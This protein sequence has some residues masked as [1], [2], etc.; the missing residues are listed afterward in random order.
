LNVLMALIFALTAVVFVLLY[1]GPYRNP[2][3]LSP[4]FAGSLCLFGIA[5]FSTGEFIR[6]AVRKPYIV[7]NVVLANQVLPTEVTNLRRD[8]YLEQGIWTKAFLDDHYP[9]VMLKDQDEL[10]PV[11]R[12]HELLKLPY[13]D[14][15]ALGKVL[16]LHHCND[17]HAESVGYSAAGPLLQG[18]AR[19]Q[20]LDRVKRLDDNY[21]MPPWCGTDEEAELLTDY[22]MTINW[23]R[24]P[25]TRPW[26]K[27]AGGNDAS[28]GGME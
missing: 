20:V 21:F 22:L 28:E 17:C 24:P 5:A 14:R 23:P 19:P 1:V 7:N 15:V 18:R 10:Y 4:G 16:F 27:S 12:R 26:T 6:E 13:K 9:K 2:G 8:G 25:G 11:L 3:W